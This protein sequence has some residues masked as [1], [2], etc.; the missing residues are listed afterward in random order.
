MR[1]YWHDIIPPYAGYDPYIF[2][3]IHYVQGLYPIGKV[4]SDVAYVYV[5]YFVWFLFVFTTT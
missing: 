4:L 2:V 1:L 5:S 3:L